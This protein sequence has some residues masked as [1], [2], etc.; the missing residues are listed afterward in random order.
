[1]GISWGNVVGQGILGS[2]AGGSA[3]MVHEID[4]EN[5]NQDEI[6][7]AAAKEEIAQKRAK[8]LDDLKLQNQKREEGEVADFYKS[9][10]PQTK[11]A[12]FTDTVGDEATGESAG[13]PITTKETREETAARRLEEA[14][15]TGKSGIIAQAYK[16]VGDIRAE[17]KQ[18]IAAK[19]LEQRTANEAE[20]LRLQDQRDKSKDENEKKRLDVMIAKLTKGEAA[21]KEPAKIR[22]VKALAELAFGGDIEKATSFA[23]GT[24]AKPR[25]E[26]VMSMFSALKN[27]DADTGKASD[28]M[29]KAE[30]MVDD[31][32]GKDTASRGG[33]SVGPK[34]APKTEAPKEA[35]KPKSKAEYDALAPGALYVNPKDGKTYR[36]P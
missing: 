6:K 35:A 9:T 26:A 16:E 5:K 25:A 12:A 33:V 14:R 36:K 28:L 29:A 11:T 23:Y 30:K 24:N 20:R 32:R 2:V 22:E 31:L 27:T 4:R 10:A 3:S 8:F 21:D 19:T 13:A 17:D 18:D 34:E 7:L 15:K 1:M